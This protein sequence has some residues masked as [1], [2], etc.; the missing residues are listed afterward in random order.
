MVSWNGSGDPAPVHQSRKNVSR[1]D[2]VR[3][4][5]A[6]YLNS[7]RG[8]DSEPVDAH[9][10]PRGRRTCANSRS[11]LDRRGARRRENRVP[12]ALFLSVEQR[13]HG[14]GNHPRR[15]AFAAE[16]LT[17]QQPPQAV[18][19]ARLWARRPRPRAEHTHRVEWASCWSSVPQTAGSAAT[20]GARLGRGAARQQPPMPSRSRWYR[21]VASIPGIRRMSRRARSPGEWA[22][23]RPVRWNRGCRRR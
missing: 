19:N 20:A 14:I 15:N 12:V 22:R 2:Y 11:R 17:T 8:A 10:P 9:P 13:V 4:R 23:L 6:E 3:N 5:E 21:R 16:S 1:Y 7:R 18:A